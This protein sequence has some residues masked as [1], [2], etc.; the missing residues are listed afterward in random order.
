MNT[1]VH[2]SRTSSAKTIR[3]H[4]TDDAQEEAER[5]DVTSRTDAF[6][7]EVDTEDEEGDGHQISSFL[8]GECSSNLIALFWFSGIMKNLMKVRKLY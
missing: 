8:A 7:T 5:Y 2:L 4:Y 1:S 3:T 6:L